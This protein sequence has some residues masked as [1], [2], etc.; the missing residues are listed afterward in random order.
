MDDGTDLGR[1]P[2]YASKAVASA[3]SATAPS[4]DAAMRTTA[5]ASL[6]GSRGAGST[7]H[8]H[9]SSGATPCLSASFRRAS[10]T[11]SPAKRGRG[12]SVPS[13]APRARF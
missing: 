3:A 1:V 13:R 9:T 10:A 4:A 12:R 11:L 2:V 6:A 7:V 8:M 5:S